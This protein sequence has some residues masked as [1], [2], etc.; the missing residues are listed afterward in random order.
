MKSSGTTPLVESYRRLQLRC[1]DADDQSCSVI[2]LTVDPNKPHQ[3]ITEALKRFGHSEQLTDD[4]RVFCSGFCQAKTA[5][6]TQILLQRPP[7]M[8]VLRL[9]RFRQIR[10]GSRLEKIDARVEFP[11]G[12]DER[13]DVTENAFLRDEEQRVL[14]RLVAVCAHLGSSIDSGHYISYVR[15]GENGKGSETWSKQWVRIDDDFVSVIDEAIF[16]QETLSSA[17]LLF[18]ARCRGGRLED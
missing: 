8:L 2:S 9:Q 5:R 10:G 6:L 4:N 18:Y 11:C 7:E 13:L 12:P 3:S 15:G 16:R 1:I 14:Y 17:Y